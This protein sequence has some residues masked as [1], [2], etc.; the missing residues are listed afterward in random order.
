MIG[1]YAA[2][3]VALL[4]WSIL[5]AVWLP[6]RHLSAHWD[7]AWSGFDV[8]LAGTLVAVAVTAWR[9]SMWLEGAATAAATL[10]CCDAWFD[11][12]TAAT[13]RELVFAAVEA[14][15]VELPLAFLCLWVARRSNAYW[16][17]SRPEP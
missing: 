11:L 9:R 15:F 16:L 1:I 7:I 12:L 6:A 5:L 8:A 3:A 4:P 14:A 2:A 17:R 10:L 13:T